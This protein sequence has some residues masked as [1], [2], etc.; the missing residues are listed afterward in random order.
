[1]MPTIVIKSDLRAPFQGS[2][3]G[4]RAIITGMNRI[5]TCNHKY[6]LAVVNQHLSNNLKMKHTFTECS[7]KVF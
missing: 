3:S 5:L 1:M 4:S 2:M 6:D 7:I